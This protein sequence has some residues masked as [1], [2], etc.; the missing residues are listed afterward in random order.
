MKNVLILGGYTPAHR[1]L[2]QTGEVKLYLFNY[3][4]SIK[5]YYNELYERVI[6]FKDLDVSKWVRYAEQLHDDERIDAVITFDDDLHKVAIELSLKLNISYL[7]NK[8]TIEL[9]SDKNKMRTYLKKCGFSDVESIIL[10][11]QEDIANAF[12]KFKVDVIII[13]PIDGAGSKCIYKL[14]KTDD[15]DLF[16]STLKPL[17]FNMTFIIEP[18]LVGV[19]YSVEAY[20][21]NGIHKIYC[22]TK[23]IKIIILLKS[24]ILFPQN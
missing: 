8:E 5:G 15:L 1:K 17:L 14:D 19:E 2:L 16:Y 21:E 4:K 18:Y 11:S 20:S 3:T 12:L 13:K 9:V 23:N 24:V 10:N 22:I 6:T 7:Y